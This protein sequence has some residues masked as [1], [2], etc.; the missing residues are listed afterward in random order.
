MT[1]S[2]GADGLRQDQ[3]LCAVL[4]S[5]TDSPFKA[6]RL[7]ARVACLACRQGVDHRIYIAFAFLQSHAHFGKGLI[8]VAYQIEHPLRIYMIALPQ[9]FIKPCRMVRFEQFP[10][11]C[12]KKRLRDT[13]HGHCAPRQDQTRLCFAQ[14]IGTD[15]GTGMGKDTAGR[16][17]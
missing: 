16:L 3:F 15:Q 12:K 6:V 11:V 14:P 13:V 10:V 4:K 9:H 7:K 8:S 5:L 1:K 17:G 2:S